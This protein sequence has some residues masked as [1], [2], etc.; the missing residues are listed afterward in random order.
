MVIFISIFLTIC[1]ITSYVMNKDLFSPVKFYFIALITY[2]FD[3]FLNPQFD[4]VYY[5][6][7][8]YLAFGFIL[9]FVEARMLLRFC[10][11]LDKF[12]KHVKPTLNNPLMVFSV[13]F[14]LSAIP[15]CAQLYLISIMGG[16]ELYVISMKLRV[17]A[18]MGLGHIIICR[19]LMPIINL[20]FFII[21]MCFDF[22]YKKGI[23]VVYIL[24]L[25]LKTS[26]Q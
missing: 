7:I 3:I 1:C 13:I 6:Y 10:A 4:D 9:I 20:V 19:D 25:I 26:L 5:S 18:W 2:F 24:H 17:E 14:I 12:R 15:I 8:L 11:V 22:K 23:I 16:I 21:L